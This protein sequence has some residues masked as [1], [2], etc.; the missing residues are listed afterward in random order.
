ML[1]H[2]GM[3]FDKLA[4]LQGARGF[5]REQAAR[6]QPPKIHIVLY[7]KC[8]TNI[9]STGPV[10]SFQFASG[11]FLPTWLYLWA[12]IFAQVQKR[13]KKLHGLSCTCPCTYHCNPW[14]ICMGKGRAFGVVHIHTWAALL[15]LSL[16][17]GN[18]CI[19]FQI[20]ARQPGGLWKRK[21]A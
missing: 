7:W 11:R 8:N 2:S 21:W 1:A 15:Y 17:G 13:K 6:S 20:R 18:I 3:A 5:G 4:P 14:G 12:A 19:L 9:S 16:W 10:M